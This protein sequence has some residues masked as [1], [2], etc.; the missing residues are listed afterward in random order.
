[1]FVYGFILNKS[2]TGFKMPHTRARTAQQL[3]EKKLSFQRVVLVQ[4]VRQCGKSFFLREIY[5]KGNLNSLYVTFDRPSELKFARDNPESFISRIK[6]SKPAIIDEAQKVPELFD[7]VKYFVDQDMRPGQFVLAGSTE[8]SIKSNIREALTGRATTLRLF[9]MTM[10]E[11][12][13]WPPASTLSARVRSSSSSITRDVFL[14]HLNRGGMPGIFYIHSDQERLSLMRDWL[15]LTTERDI[16]QI[17]G[18]KKDSGLAFEILEQIATLD[19]PTAMEIAKKLRI[20]ARKIASHIDALK[21]LFAVVQLDPSKFGSGK[22]RLYLCD[23]GFA[24]ELGASFKRQIETLYLQE[25]MAWQSYKGGV[26]ELSY[27]RTSKGSI[28]DFIFRDSSK[29]YNCIKI[30]DRESVN[31]L[32]IR[33]LQSLAKKFDEPMTLI[34]AAGTTRVQQLAGVSIVPWEFIAGQS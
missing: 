21:T 7:T 29:T 1:M 27:Y 16:Q 3:F 4:G 28:V 12:L 34:C 33:N 25:L 30:H 6:E 5:A 24:K 8:F 14:R 13:G 2:R 19:D 17:P 15:Q 20:S 22:P 9:P 10:R 23:V 31:Q 18:P 26:D 11:S 32:D